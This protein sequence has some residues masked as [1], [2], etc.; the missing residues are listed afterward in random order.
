[1]YLVYSILNYDD[2]HD[3]YF[4][5]ITHTFDKAVEVTIEAYKET[6]PDGDRDSEIVYGSIDREKEIY[7]QYYENS[8][9]HVIDLSKVDVLD[10]P[11]T[12]DDPA[13]PE[14]K[15]VENG[16]KLI[17]RPPMASDVTPSRYPFTDE[18]MEL[19]STMIDSMVNAKNRSNVIG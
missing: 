13:E 12:E 14:E 19:I 2:G 15:N 17:E 18:Q 11:S 7:N 16:P 8:S 5:G 4:N 1:M 3:L 9:Y 10:G 6:N